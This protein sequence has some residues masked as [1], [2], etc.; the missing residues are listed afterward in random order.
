M[1]IQTEIIAESVGRGDAPTTNP[2][3]CEAVVGAT[4]E[5]PKDE[6]QNHHNHHKSINGIISD[7]NI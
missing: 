4:G 5:S 7:V 6:A 3:D 2:I 1:I